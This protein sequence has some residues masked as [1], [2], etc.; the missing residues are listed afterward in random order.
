AARISLNERWA[1]PTGLAVHGAT[2]FP[3]ADASVRDPVSGA[4]E[5][6]LDNARSRAN[7][8]KVFY[9]NTPVEYWGTGR[10]AALVHTTPDGSADLAL[11]ENVRF[12]FFAGTQHG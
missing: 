2:A 9:T 1:T 11:P 8:P 5:G 6:L 12:Y 3:F 7:Q 10:V 4:Q